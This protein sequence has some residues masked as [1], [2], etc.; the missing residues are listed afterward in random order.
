MF[1]LSNCC[2]IWGGTI[3]CCIFDTGPSTGAD[4]ISGVRENAGAGEGEVEGAGAVAIAGAGS[5][6][7]V[8]ADAS[9]GVDAIS[10][11]A[12]RKGVMA[13]TVADARKGVEAGTDICTGAVAD[14][15]A[16]VDVVACP[17]EDAFAGAPLLVLRVVRVVTT[18]SGLYVYTVPRL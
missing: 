10:R 13:D 16:V 9:E 18:G 17:G 6:T 8:D 7:D 11:A 2:C 3:F 15:D 12:A 4:T 1:I 5:S 14:V